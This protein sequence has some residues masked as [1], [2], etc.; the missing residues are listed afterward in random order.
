MTAP[1]HVDLARAEAYARRV[2]ADG[3]PVVAAVA[4]TDL[5]GCECRPLDELPP[6]PKAARRGG[7]GHRP[8]ATCQCG[9][10]AA[11]HEPAGDGADRDQCTA[12]DCACGATS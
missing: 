5:R 12:L 3:G 10:P 1:V 11:V 7:R 6:V 8:R 4:R 9:H 2:V